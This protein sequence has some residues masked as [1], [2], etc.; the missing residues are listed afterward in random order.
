MRFLSDLL[1]CLRFYSRLPV[2]VLRWEAEP[3]AMLDFGHAIRAL[4]LAGLIIAAPAA[5]LL[6]GA[7]KILPAEIAAALALTLFVITTGAFH[8]DGLADTADGLG[9]GR[10]LERKLEIMRDS[11]IGTFG[12]AALVLSL[13]LRWAALTALLKMGPGLAACV[14]L[15]AAGLSRWLGLMPV[16]L[17]PA[18]RTDGAAFA[19]ARPRPLPLALGGLIA[20]ALLA[21]PFW[22]GVPAV[23]LALAT[24]LAGIAALAMTRIS[25][26]QIKGQ[27][28][29]I[30][31]AA[32]QLAE[33]TF[34]VT[35]LLRI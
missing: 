3:H 13:L 9:G 18:A 8:E 10:S 24:V 4:P 29:D 33:I 22:A 17:L 19:A 1:A 34:L 7:A 23:R 27:T 26:A 20:L 30:A 12:G 25:K 35:I 14:M 5:A 32:Q 15:G 6:F 2:P 31:G 16:F 21:L 28:G 11:R